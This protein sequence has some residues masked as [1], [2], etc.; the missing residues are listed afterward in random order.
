MGCML[1]KVSVIGNALA[2]TN[3]PES[4]AGQS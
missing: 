3:R 1:Q 4:R 2:V